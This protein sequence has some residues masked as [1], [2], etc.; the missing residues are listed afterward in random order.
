MSTEEKK[1][2]RNGTSA[3][4]VRSILRRTTILG[5]VEADPREGRFAKS[6]Y[7][8][9]KRT[10]KTVNPITVIS[11][12]ITPSLSIFL[13]IFNGKILKSEVKFSKNEGILKE[14]Y[15]YFYKKGDIEIS[16]ELLHFKNL[17][18]KCLKVY[19]FLKKSVNFGNVITYGELSEELSLHPRFVGY[20]MKINP[21]PVII[22]CHRV[23]SK[24]GMGGYS[25][26]LEIKKLL[27][28]HEGITDS[29]IYS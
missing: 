21:F 11:S 14:F 19:S 4:S 25:Q 6:V 8:L 5:A 28:S 13:Y 3:Q 20:C 29:K 10:K 18:E 15:N 1:G 27:L 22:P 2:I 24:K 17:N 9:R 7:F 26:G 12:K 16:S 23:V